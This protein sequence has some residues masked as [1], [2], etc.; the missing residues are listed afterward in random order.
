MSTASLSRL[1]SA[2]LQT[3]EIEQDRV[4][5]GVSARRESTSA[6]RGN[7]VGNRLRLVTGPSNGATESRP[8]WQDCGGMATPCPRQL[9]AYSRSR[10]S[11]AAFLVTP[12][13][14]RI[15]VFEAYLAFTRVTACTLAESPEA[16]PI[17]PKCFKSISL[18]LRTAPIAVGWNEQVAGRVYFP[19]RCGALARPG[20][21]GRLDDGI[22]APTTSR[23]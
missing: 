9:D 17:A 11:L 5:R 19:L 7:F 22:C 21:S 14:P 3:G 18:P 8:F 12:G 16:A 13:R 23:K 2:H 6:P 15:D 20:R 1:V 4:R 10:R